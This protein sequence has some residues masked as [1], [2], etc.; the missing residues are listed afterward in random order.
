MKSM[1]PENRFHANFDID[2]VFSIKKKA[3]SNGNSAGVDFGSYDFLAG[4]AIFRSFE[5]Q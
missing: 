2:I 1:P 5:N 3:V 4:Q